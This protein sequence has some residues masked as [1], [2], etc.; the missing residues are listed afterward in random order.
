[1]TV[2]I[3]N[4]NGQ[5]Y[6]S[7]AQIA[8][9]MVAKIAS[10]NMGFNILNQFYYN[11]PDEPNDVRLS[12]FDGILAG[13]NINDV[14][15]FQSPSWNS[16]T[17]DNEFI[18]HVSIYP[19]VKKI[20]FVH[21]IPPLMFE[22]N[23]Y[24]LPNFIDYY[25]KADVIILP[26]KKMF[27]FLRQNGLTVKKV[28]FQKMWDHVVRINPFAL[29]SQNKKIINFAGDPEKF[30][31]VKEWDYTEV[32]LHLFADSQEWG[33]GKNIKFMGWQDDPFL[34]NSLRESGGFGL[35][36]GTEP[37]WSEYMKLNASYKLS[38]YLAAGIPVIVNSTTPERDTI[39][40]KN[41]GIIADSLDEA[42]DKVKSISD[43][44]YQKMTANVDTFGSLIRGGY[45]TKRLL[46]EAVFKTRYE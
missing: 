8:Q 43:E 7:V 28:V 1:M 22:S 29:S 13:L 17:W 34:V 41:L 10:Q 3:T 19:G 24:L 36:W 25:N 31:F 26:S 20:I 2:H 40:R 9:N 35:V 18:D 16:L 12:R 21:D 5:G 4:L 23:R 27:D 6:Q 33:Q 37:Y 45:F 15:I 30:D 42:V 46:S 11:W 14:V 44:Q 39:I 32:Q 38:T